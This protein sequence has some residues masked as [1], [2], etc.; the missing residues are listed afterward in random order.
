M[1][2]EEYVAKLDH[3]NMLLWIAHREA[4]RRAKQHEVPKDPY[5]KSQESP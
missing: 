5:P 2:D 4:V 3:Q 1:T